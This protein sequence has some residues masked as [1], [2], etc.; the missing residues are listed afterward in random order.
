MFTSRSSLSFLRTQIFR[1]RRDARARRRERLVIRKQELAEKLEKRRLL[2]EEKGGDMDAVMRAEAESN[3]PEEMPL[4]PD[5][6]F[7]QLKLFYV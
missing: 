6:I 7:R 2:I 1:E 5:A 4:E 3:Q